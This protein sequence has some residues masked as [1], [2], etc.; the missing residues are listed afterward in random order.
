MDDESPRNITITPANFKI[1]ENLDK[2]GLL[3][4]KEKLIKNKIIPNMTVN[5]TI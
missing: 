5:T 1:P 3:F 2:F 4:L